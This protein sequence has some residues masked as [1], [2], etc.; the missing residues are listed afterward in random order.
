M[1]KRYQVA[2]VGAGP[3][4]IF[5]ALTLSNDGLEN[6]AIFASSNS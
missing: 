6:M 2:I 5:A 1:R 4:A 3:S